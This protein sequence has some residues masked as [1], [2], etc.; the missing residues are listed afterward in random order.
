MDQA[1][2]FRYATAAL[3]GRWQTTRDEALFDALRAGQAFQ[4][5][6]L[7]LLYAFARIETLSDH[8]AEALH[9][10]GPSPFP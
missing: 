8:R 1:E 2:R 7:I 3:R 5:G 9:L 10:A 6:E 4:R